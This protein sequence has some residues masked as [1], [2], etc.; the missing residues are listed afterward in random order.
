V[1][2]AQSDL[3]LAEQQLARIS[4]LAERQAESRQNLD[5][6]SAGIGDAEAALALAQ[7]RL[8]EARAGP[9]AEER[10]LADAR[11][12]AAEA[13]VAVLQSRL[14]KTSLLAPAD[15]VIRVIAAEPGEAVLPGRPVLTEETSDGTWFS[16]VLREDRL[17]G[18]GV[19]SGVSLV[20]ADG[21]RLAA[22]VTE[23]RGLG[24]YAT[25]RA[26]R[27]VGDHDLNTLSLRADPVDEWDKG[28]I[29]PGM[30]VWLTGAVR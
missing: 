10:A 2:K 28:R 30:T 13:A 14:A 11:L 29:E 12:A 19:G 23:L 16:F 24:D 18:L 20:T 1:G 17:D 15:G 25:W 8:A 7:A 21:R 4:V 22:R 26:A 27:A 5:K 9:T 6:S 3:T